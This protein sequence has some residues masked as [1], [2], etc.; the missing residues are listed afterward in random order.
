MSSQSSREKLPFEPTSKKKKT[1]KNKPVSSNKTPSNR[2]RAKPNTQANSA[3]PEVVS[4]RMI[5]RMA[6]FCGIPT[7]LGISSFIGSYVVVSQEWF[8]LP[9][10]AVL[11][12]SM[13]WFGLGVL[14]LSY[15]VLSASWDEERVGS[16]WGCQEFTVNWGRTVNA[17]RSSRQEAK[18]K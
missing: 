1:P 11:L 7:A 13:G 10:Y 9:T 16:W 17:W 6:L 14:G 4:K 2:D 12:V 5:K 15:G 3:I 18:K 8:A